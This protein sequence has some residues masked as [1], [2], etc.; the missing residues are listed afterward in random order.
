[1]ARLFSRITVLTL[2]AVIVFHA[3]H[4]VFAQY[5]SLP[6]DKGRDKKTEA[7][8]ALSS[9]AGL[10]DGKSATNQYLTYFF[11][12]WTQES[13]A[14]E[15]VSYRTK[16]LPELIAVASGQS[17]V[18]L[19][20]RCKT[21]LA[22]LAS[23]P[24]Y[25][26]A[27]RYNAMY[28][29]GT[30]NQEE[31]SP[32][33]PYGPSVPDLI[34]GYE[35]KSIPDGIRLAA[36]E[37]LR[38]HAMLGIVEASV[39]DTQVVP[40]LTQIALDTP[41]HEPPKEEDRAKTKREVFVEQ[42]TGLSQTSEPQRSVE[43]QNW[44][45]MRAI[46]ALGSM[47][48]TNVAGDISRTLLTLI[49]NP[50]ETP[51]IKYEAAFALSQLELKPEDQ[52]DLLQVAKSLVELAILVC[53]D[54]V[55][56]MQEQMRLQQVMSS[57]GVSAGGIG[58]GMGMSGPSGMGGSSM[59]GG[60]GGPSLG[61]GS[62]GM[63]GGMSMGG[64][65]MSMGMGSSGSLGG[66]L[67]GLSGAGSTMSETQITQIN[68]SLSRI[69]YGFSSI[70]ACIN[71]PN[72]KG[73]GVV[74]L[75]SD[76]DQ[77]T[78]GM[79]ENLQAAITKCVKFLDDGDPVK[80]KQAAAAKKAGTASRGSEMGMGM[81]TMPSMSSG[82]GPGGRSGAAAAK[83]PKVDEP[84]VTMREIEDQLTEA[85]QTFRVLIDAPSDSVSPTS[86]SAAP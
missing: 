4:S 69:K 75:I 22:Q 60:M 53:D 45:R 2:F 15:L 71:G 54:S 7:M 72:Y 73:K 50:L 23:N 24:K 59:G 18:E 9:G 82:A 56:F 62:M 70:S 65:S 66:G 46:Q 78:K 26:P 38:R 51:V 28:A 52:T 27:C 58:G 47:K 14:A 10:G 74:L 32:P 79:L 86:V 6:I 19:L 61:G 35:N 68:N 37:G 48:G 12:R 34:K 80:I 30:L 57:S 83:T 8:N 85:K 84:K 55:L 29:L 21:I 64:S 63:G 49:D 81:M 20:N 33:V 25:Y 5:A 41:Y 44:F 11:A 42:E 13:L 36:L 1:M 40:L 16:E 17:K 39:R 31:G 43:I 77:S 3:S 67:G 76:N